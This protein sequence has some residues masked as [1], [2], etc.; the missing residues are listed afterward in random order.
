M[1]IRDSLQGLRPAELEV[2]QRVRTK[3]AF[4][5]TSEDDLALLMSRRVLEYVG[6]KQER[7]YVVHPTIVP[8]LEQLAGSE[9]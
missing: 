7:R 5:Q 6:A 8:F 2:L 1:C 3:G 9:W 4:V